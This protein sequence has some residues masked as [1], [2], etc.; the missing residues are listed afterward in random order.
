MIARLAIVVA[1]VSFAP[2]A[3]VTPT[4]V[5]AM[6]RWVAA[7]ES[8]SRPGTWTTACGRCGR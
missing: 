3:D 2:A 4:T 7:V 8:A 1:L 6:Q 5:L